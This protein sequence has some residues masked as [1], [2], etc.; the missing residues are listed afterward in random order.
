MQVQKELE[1]QTGDLILFRGTSWI[2]TI[3]E[4]VGK[5]T[6]SQTLLYLTNCLE[7]HLEK[8]PTK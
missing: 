1:L 7:Y 3:L 5:K 6:I 4:Y 2:S 8:N